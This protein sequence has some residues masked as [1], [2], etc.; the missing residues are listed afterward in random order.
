[1]NETPQEVNDLLDEGTGQ[2]PYD[3]AELAAFLDTIPEKKT[4]NYGAQDVIFHAGDRCDAVYY[5]VEGRVKLSIV[6]QLGKEAVLALLG[7]EQ[8]VGE[9]NLAGQSTYHASAVAMCKSRLWR[10]R[11]ADLLNLIRQERAFAITM[12]SYLLE[13]N[14]RLRE[15]LAS[16]L[17]N[18]TERR[19]ARTLLLLAHFGAKEDAASK[20]DSLSHQ[21]LAEI[22]GTTRARVTF[23]MNR[24]RRLGYLEYDR[25]QI[26]VTRKLYSVLLNN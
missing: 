1:M 26:R 19:L 10:I 13:Q 9:C 15:E 21:T 8:F 6:S 12:L 24:F 18:S 25:R 14:N 17:V 3:H 11:S 16:Q 22:V 7:P 5:I 2:E 23:F 4:V 20:I